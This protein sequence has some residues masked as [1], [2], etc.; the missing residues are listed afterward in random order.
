ARAQPAHSYRSADRRRFALRGWWRLR[1]PAR[2]SSPVRKAAARALRSGLV[3]WD[4]SRA[5][6]RRRDGLCPTRPL[7]QSE[8][9]YRRES[10]AKATAFARILGPPL[11]GI[12][13]RAQ[14]AHSYEGVGWRLFPSRGWW[15]LRVPA[16]VSS[17]AR[18]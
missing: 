17:P 16:R 15:R 7:T 2:V 8:I 14:P 3:V 11:R 18:K 4:R 5:Y 6:I 13:A 1:V 9:T 10:L 12:C